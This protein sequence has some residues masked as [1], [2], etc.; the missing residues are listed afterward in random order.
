M[1][2]SMTAIVAASFVA[3]AAVAYAD[4]SPFKCAPDETYVMNVMVSGVEYWFPVY[5]MFKQAGQQFGCKT[6]YTGTPEYDVSKQIASFEQA[7]ARQPAGIL[8]HPMNADPFIEPINRAIAQG[9]AVVTFA[10]DSPNSN[11]ISYITSDNTREGSVAADAVAKAMKESGTYAV[12][13]NPGQDNHDKRVS[14]FIARMKEAYPGM[15]LV[16]R[17]NTNQDPTKAYQALLSLAQANPNLGAVFMPEASSALG[18]SQAAVELGG[19]I[20]VMTVDINSKILDMIKAGDVFG[21]IN[22]NQGAQGY[23]GFLL[24]WLAKHPELIDPMNDH[25]RSGFNPMSIPVL[26]NGYSIVTAENADDFYWDS[27]LKRRGTKGID[28]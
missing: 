27:Y 20:K 1:K 10:A 4:E 7:L 6:A 9:T 16:G 28:E 24:L 2:R 17:A 11:R 15:K 18:A 13:E 19:K 21:A 3:S 8:L 14:A 12:L 25:A 26:D 23:Y 5:E 22:P